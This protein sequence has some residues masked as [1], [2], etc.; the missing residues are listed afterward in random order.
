MNVILNPDSKTSKLYRWFYNKTYYNRPENLCS[1]CW[2]LFWMYIIIIPYVFIIAPG[3][4]FHRFKKASF[5]SRIYSSILSVLLLFMFVGFF[6]APFVLYFSESK[7]HLSN[8]PNLFLQIVD[9]IGIFTWLFI[10]SVSFALLLTIRYDMKNNN[11]QFSSN[12][13]SLIKTKYNKIC[14]KITWKTK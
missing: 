10:F 9:L 7:L 12:I 2:S 3:F 4:I 8:E 6:R 14:P 1:Y 11:T 5:F 13:G